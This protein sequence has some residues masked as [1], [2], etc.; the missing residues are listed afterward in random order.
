MRRLL[1]LYLT[2]VFCAVPAVV[3]SQSRTVAANQTQTI[4]NPGAPA[5]RWFVG[6]EMGAVTHQFRPAYSSPDG[7]FLGS[8]RDVVTGGRIGAL[9]G[10]ELVAVGPIGVAITGRFDVNRATWALVVNDDLSFLDSVPQA[11]S[12]LTYKIPY[13]ATLT[14]QPRL[15]VG[16]RVYL[17]GELGAGVAR[18]EQLKTSRAGSTYDFASSRPLWE[19]A[20]GVS[21]RFGRG[22][23][24][25]FVVRRPA[26][27][28][29]AFKSQTPSGAPA[30]IIHDAPQTAVIVLGLV[31]PFGR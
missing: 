10:Y 28:G 15:P 18:I 27:S 5:A 6:A 26:Y 9:L 3:R 19:A 17:L 14:I 22:A 21:A 16:S 30:E 20:V 7:G 1:Y 24:I 8:F 12:S 31:V 29:Y 11:Q 2:I 13:T 25:Y 4:W 23:R